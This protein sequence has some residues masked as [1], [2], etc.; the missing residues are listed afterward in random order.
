MAGLGP[1][2]YPSTIGGWL[3]PGRAGREERQG[4]D[5]QRPKGSRGQDPRKRG[6]SPQGRRRGRRDRP[7]RQQAQTGD[8]AAPPAGRDDR[9]QR[10]GRP[11]NARSDEGRGAPPKPT[12]P[13]RRERATQPRSKGN[14]GEERGRQGPSPPPEEAAGGPP[15]RHRSLSA[16]CRH[17]ERSGAAGPFLF[18]RN[19]QHL[20]LSKK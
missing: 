10:G 13:A 18:L 11:Q 14:G 15:T 8:S 9:A 3:Q 17:R 16:R 6:H 5:Q 12:R 20:Q 2:T 4:Q 7:E 19:R 1:S